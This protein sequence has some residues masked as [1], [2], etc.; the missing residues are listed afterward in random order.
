[1]LDY[2]AL[3][4]LSSVVEQQGFDRAAQAL[5]L[6]QSAV[7]QRIKQLEA[8]LGQ[9]VVLRQ[10]PP[11]ATTLGK[12]LIS[13]LHTVQHLERDLQLPND[14]TRLK[15]RI[16]VNADSLSTWFA[17]AL[18]PITDEI[19]INL[20]IA[21]QDVGIDWMKRGEVL[22]CLCSASQ[23]VNGAYVDSL[24]TLRYR[25]YAS[26]A[27]RERH[28]LNKDLSRLYQ[29]PCLIFNQ[30]DQLQHRFLEMLGQP[31]PAS[32]TICPS[33]EGFLQLALSDCGFGL[34][35]EVQ[36]RESVEQGLLVDIAPGRYIDTP[37]YWHSWH[38]TGNALK[39]LRQSVMKTARRW[40]AQMP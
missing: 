39:H 14:E 12:R 31:A 37:L 3:A 33:S 1:M 4:A 20:V 16:A 40:L 18:G 28:R 32:P 5:G 22:A 34:M 35:P 7:S 24:G 8:Q 17:D 30:D 2:R 26:P 9:P 19:D 23:A 15:A 27:F 38:T 25:A 13:H 29:A 10:T 36:A 6:T 21:D 11:V